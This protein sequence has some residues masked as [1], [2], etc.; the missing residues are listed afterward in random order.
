MKAIKLFIIALLAISA[1]SSCTTTS[2]HT[3]ADMYA[4]MY[5]QHPLSIA[6][7]PPI[8]KTN[9]VDAKEYLFFTLSQPLAERGY[10]VFPAFLTMEMFKSESAYDAE[11]YKDGSLSKFKEVLGADAVLFTTITKWEKAAAASSVRVEVE[12]S[13]K[14]TADN[15]EIFHRKGNIVYDASLNT[16]GGGLLGALVGMA[17]NAINT[18][19]TPHVKVARAA[20]FYTLTDMPAGQYS[21][22]YNLDQTKP[23]GE[24]VFSVTTK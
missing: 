23:A 21:P 5:G 6:V 7:M 15:K 1:L 24:E 19:A 8:N 3:K 18:A 16:S 14:S 13:L 11:M 4:A 2:K 17:A 22:D 10:Y 9:N 12:Y 20:N